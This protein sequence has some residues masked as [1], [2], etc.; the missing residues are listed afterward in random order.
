MT[1]VSR[2]LAGISESATMAI[3]TRARQMRAEGRP[4]ISYGAGEPDYP[5]PPHIVEAAAAAVADPANH[6]YSA[7]AGLPALREAVAATT[8]ADDGLEIDPGQVLITNGGKQAVFQTFAALLDPGDEVIVPAPFWVTYPEAIKL[9]GGV[10]VVVDTTAADGFLADVERLE[11]ARTDRTKAIMFVSPSNPTGAVYG[12]DQT[13]AIGEWAAHHGLWVL[14]DDIYQHLVYGEARFTSLPGVTP[15]LEDRWVIISGVSKTWAMTG[16]RVGWM[17]G[18]PDVISAAA[19][20]Q[21]HATSNVSNVSQRAA[22]AAMTG[23]R[24]AAD[25]M[26]AG[27]DRRRRLMHGLLAETPGVQCVEPLGAFY[28]FPS[29]SDVLAE[30]AGGRSFSSGIDLC[31][32]LLEEAEIALVPGEAFGAPGYAR[33][34]YALGDADISEGLGRL[35]RFLA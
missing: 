24:D 15:E 20:H 26:R 5:T 23:P 21:S 11:A 7:N 4:V 30:G 31:A 16:W 8:S 19:N 25:E 32:A 13:R 27:F 35:R 3:S 28:C 1:R 9:A 14:S 2:R 6:K 10:P 34:S 18:P 17:I 22:I 33:L 12:R 29:F